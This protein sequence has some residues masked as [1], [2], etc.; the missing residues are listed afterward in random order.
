MSCSL[1]YERSRVCVDDAQNFILDGDHIQ[2]DSARKDTTN[3]LT[4]LVIDTC[5]YI[6][7]FQ[8]CIYNFK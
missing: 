6:F 2:P 4:K 3:V 7:V 8:S 1:Q 5:A